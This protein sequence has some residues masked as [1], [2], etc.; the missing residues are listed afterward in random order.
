MK[1]GVITFHS[2]H[3]FGASLQ[4]WALQQALLGLG[5]EPCVINYH[6]PVIDELYDPVKES[7][8]RKRR[9][10]IKQLEKKNPKSLLRFERYNQFIK[11]NFTLFGNYTCYEDL[12][13]ETKHLDAYITGS[14]QVWNSQ[15]IGG[16]DPAYFL[17][18]VPEEALK[19]SYAASTGRSYILP[20]YHDKVSHALE[21]FTSIAV[22]EASSAPAVQALTKHQVNVVADPTFLLPKEKYD[23][24]KKKPELGEKYIFVYMMENNPEVVK[25][26]NS[27]SR[28]LGLPIVQR[29]QKKFFIN[30]IDNTYTS[31]PDEWLGFI[32]NAELVITNSFHGTVFSAIF[33]KPFISMLHSDTGSRT[34]DLLKALELEDHIIYDPSTFDNFDQFE[35]KD[36]ELLRKRIE[37]LRNHGLSY[38]RTALKLDVTDDSSVNC[39]TC[40]KIK[41]CYGC[42]ACEAVCPTNAITMMGDREGFLYPNVDPTTCIMC[43]ACS[44]ACIRKHNQLKSPEPDYPKVMAAY[45]KD[46][47][48]RMNSS[49]GAIFPELARIAIEEKQGCVVG[50]KFDENMNPISSI[51]ST[52]EEVKAFYGSK[53]VKSDF[54][55]IFQKVKEKLRQGTFVLYTGLPCEC[56][57][58]RAY[59]R[60]TYDNLII[61]EILCHASPSPKVFRSYLDYLE[62]KFQSK[63][64]DAKFRDK[65]KGWLGHENTLVFQFANGKEL[66]VNARKNN[67]FRAFQKDLICRPS[68]SHCEYTY[69]NRIGDITLGDFWGVRIAEPELFDDKGISFIMLNNE[70]AFSYFELGKE[71]LFTK[72]ITTYTAFIKNH[73]KPNPEKPERKEV[74]SA[75]DKTPINELLE[76][77]NDLKKK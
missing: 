34:V 16:Y 18:F 46:E 66:A 65:R 8:P 77:Y 27:I 3:N 9:K 72:D 35:I 32:D 62:G 13:K 14:D 67:Y 57:G 4:T 15:H 40:I 30:E 12:L 11:D 60:K 44:K 71:R 38:L 24:M 55:G 36:K 6:T 2:A 64:I 39:P 19:I 53:Y 69:E 50:V 75:L 73:K 43:G 20:I 37:T 21:S 41:E 28:T 23:A 61:C 17:E 29:R 1:A 45:H 31:T 25:F 74:F 76:N 48:I 10:K 33:E 22:R 26:A 47:N 42:R 63:I 68:C 5:V 54:K 52:M 70:K 56:A 59:L 7:D 58:L 51:A 49:S